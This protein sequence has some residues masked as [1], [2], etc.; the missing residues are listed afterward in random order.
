MIKDFEEKLDYLYRREKERERKEMR[1]TG[2]IY[3]IIGT[4]LMFVGFFIHRMSREDDDY[5]R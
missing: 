3:I 5:G 2:F 1:K 4:L